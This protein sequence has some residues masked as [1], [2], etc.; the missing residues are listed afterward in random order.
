MKLT[1]SRSKYSVDLSQDLDDAAVSLLVENGLNSR[2]PAACEVW[3]SRNAESRATTKKSII[4]KRKDVDE[5]L[6]MDQT[7]LEGTLAR[8]IV[9]RILEKYPYVLLFQFCFEIQVLMLL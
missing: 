3:K 1:L 2:F 6:K 8:E 7:L 9:R 5:Q 4:E